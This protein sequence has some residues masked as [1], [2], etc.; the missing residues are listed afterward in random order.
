M[1]SV[2]GPLVALGALAVALVGAELGVRAFLSE[3]TRPPVWP[4][5]YEPDERFGFRYRPGAVERLP[6]AYQ[7]KINRLGFHDR[8]P[9]PAGAAGLRVVAVG[10]SFTAGLHVPRARTWPQALENILRARG[11]A[12]DVINLGLDGTGTDVHLELLRAYLPEIRPHVVL[13]AFFANDVPDVLNGR[14]TR[15]C[16]RGAILSYQN[17]GQR[18]ALRADIDRHLERR[19]ARLG[20][21]HSHLARLAI[22]ALEGPRSPFFMRFQQPSASEL[23]VDDALRREQA[24]RVKQAWRDVE[25]LARDC[26]CRFA[27]VPVPPRG[28]L[29]GSWRAY[30]SSAGETSLEGIDV[31][32]ALRAALTAARRPAS[33]LH[34]A[35]DAHL[36]AY[37]NRLFARAIADAIDWDAAAD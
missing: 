32:P 13:L 5:V 29:R 37:G 22:R 6:G 14:F 34:F 19:L 35:A 21:E 7:V 8:E 33:S 16:Y 4:C 36:N 20:F 23:G 17:A 10:D 3:R 2:A 30:Q 9:L 26:D 31:V 27:V 18:D 25:R 12:A 1:K 15:E 24:P 11:Y 28:D